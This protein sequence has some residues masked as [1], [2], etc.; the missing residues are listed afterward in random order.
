MAIRNLAYELTIGGAGVAPNI[1]KG[2]FGTASGV[3]K[4]DAR[5]KSLRET[6]IG[7]NAE[8]KQMRGAGLQGTQA[9]QQLQQSA[10]G[11]KEELG[12]VGTALRKAQHEQRAATETSRRHRAM[13]VRGAAVIAAV[14]TAYT[15][16]GAAI[17]GVS[18][19]KGI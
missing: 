2:L 5:S 12:E 3:E 7:Q 4:L 6:L 17:L 8:L 13:M 10:Q 18:R 11:T 19:S 9:Y 15:L 14:T 1:A 16:M